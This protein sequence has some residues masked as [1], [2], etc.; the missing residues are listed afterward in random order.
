MDNVNTPNLVEGLLSTGIT[1]EVAN[2][3][4]SEPIRYTSMGE[5]GEITDVEDWMIIQAN[6]I[7]G[8]T[9]NSKKHDSKVRIS[10][11]DI[12]G[13][14]PAK[15]K[16]VKSRV[17]KTYIAEIEEVFK[18]YQTLANDNV[19]KVEE[20]TDTGRLDSIPDIFFS[21]DFNLENTE[22][23]TKVFEMIGKVEIGAEGMINAEDEKEVEKQEKISKYLNIV[24]NE[25]NKE[26]E[27]RSGS[28]FGVLSTLQKLQA[29]TQ[30]CVSEIKKVLG[31]VRDETKNECIGVSKV[32]KSGG[33]NH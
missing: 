9:Q 26:V 27:K 30:E 16:K 2:F 21:P 25:I 3:E 19:N 23:F 28:F 31:N 7:S 20:S 11:S 14:T 18:E 10:K 29:E 12:T 8:L 5:E 1:Q 17:Y 6:S 15:F 33:G 22:I 32:R 13:V 24:E 4:D